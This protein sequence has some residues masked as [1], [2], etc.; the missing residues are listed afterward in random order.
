MKT[1]IKRLFDKYYIVVTN[2]E[3]LRRYT[4]LAEK[5]A[6]F[7]SVVLDMDKLAKHVFF[8]Y[9]DEALNKL[10]ELA[11]SH[12]ARTIQYE[13]FGCSIPVFVCMEDATS[14]KQDVDSKLLLLELRK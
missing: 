12:N 1:Y 14:F 13:P 3:D 10:I 9:Y 2:E 6:L 5:E 4:S 8:P 11:K 7:N